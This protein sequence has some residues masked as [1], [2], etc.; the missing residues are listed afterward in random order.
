[1]EIV[2]IIVFAVVGLW[3]V[4]RVW[5]WLNMKQFELTEKHKWL[6]I[7]ISVLCGYVLCGFVIIGAVIK[8]VLKIVD[9]GR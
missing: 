1:M 6:K 7:L 8:L 9:G 3:S 5:N 2:L 4:K